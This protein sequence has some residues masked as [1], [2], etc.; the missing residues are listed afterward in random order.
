[1]NETKDP[2]RHLTPPRQLE[3]LIHLAFALTIAA[4]EE[5]ARA[6]ADPARAVA[7]LRCY[8]ELTHL[9]AGQARALSK[10]DSKH[11]P[12]E[13]LLSILHETAAQ[14]GRHEQ[15]ASAMTEALAFV[16]S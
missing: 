16:N 10:E 2:L 15:L 13:V 3:W 8:N 4:R 5:Y 12:H 7:A 1:M 6:E 9:I 14:G 11:Y